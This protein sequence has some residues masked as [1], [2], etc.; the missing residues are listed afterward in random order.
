MTD[1]NSGARGP[2]GSL[3]F[4]VFW[5]M[6]LTMLIAIAAVSG[7]LFYEFNQHVDSMRDRSLTGQ[8][9]DLVRH[10]S[11]SSLDRLEIDLPPALRVAYAVERDPPRFA[12]LSEAGKFLVGSPRIE[13]PLTL[14]QIPAVGAWRFFES[15]DPIA[16]TPQYGSIYRPEEWRG[17]LIIQVTQS[18]AHHDVLADTVLDEAV[19]EYL[20]VVLIVF[21]AI[22]TVTFLSIKQALKPL[23]EAS[24]EASAIG[25]N[26]LDR[27][28]TAA[29]LPTEVRPLA[30]A[31]NS[32]LDRVEEGFRI[33]QRF[34][35]DAAHEMRTPI[36][37]LHAHVERLGPHRN[38]TLKSDLDNL[39]RVVAQLLKL[40][41]VD[42]LVVEDQ[43]RADLCDVA[44]N[45][46]S[47]LA[48]RALRQERSLALEGPEKC[49]VRGDPDALEVALRNLVE[50]ALAHT[51]QGGEVDIE[52]MDD[53][54]G[55]RVLDRGPGIP[56]QDRDQLFDRFW[57]KDRRTG[58]GAGLGL[59]IVARIAVGHGATLLVLDRPG[60]GAIFEMR[61]SSTP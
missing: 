16:G 19:D 26:S 17:E 39:E 6:G 20:W 56:R 34:T 45:V 37:L 30:D 52:V 57:R 58:T 24:R 9:Q 43:G 10:L 61:F 53:P 28:L 36:A 38:A 44:R 40:A 51:G 25:P 8:T 31:I 47:F 12:I 48:P 13:G 23:T 46:V 49:V 42:A 21:G 55:L 50:N 29:G 11:G 5:R 33:Q 54:P 32:A 4:A 35:A 3:L 14:E 7:L 18:A 22:L 1:H 60:G 2:R 27:R 41:Q 59:S 15:T